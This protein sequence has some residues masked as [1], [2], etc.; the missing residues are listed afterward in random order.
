MKGRNHSGAQASMVL[1]D[2]MNG[3]ANKTL[4]LA[5]VAMAFATRALPQ[6]EAAAIDATQGGATSRATV[7]LASYEI[8]A[9]ELSDT[10][11][12]KGADPETPQRIE[13]PDLHATAKPGATA[14]QV[15]QMAAYRVNE[16][17]VEV[18]RPRDL[19]TRDGMADI[20]YKAHPGL[21]I[22]NPDHLNKE[23]AY[24]LFLEDDWRRTKSDYWS[25]AHSMEL[26]GDRGE[27]RMIVNEVNDADL[28]VRAQDEDNTFSGE[29]DRFQTPQTAG[30]LRLSDISEH[31][32]DIPFVRVKW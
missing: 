27:G 14:L 2:P 7:Q 4:A 18:F 12:L 32:L 22:G 29:S 11:D 1:L 6:S 8:A 20:S 16:P 30:G 3:R 15:P 24:Q 17:Q 23:A 31:P 25:M 19:F 9:P 13:T 26:G 28:A 10:Y 5:I 21:L